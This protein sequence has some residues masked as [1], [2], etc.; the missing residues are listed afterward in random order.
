MTN[1]FLENYLRMYSD[2]STMQEIGDAHGVTRQNVSYHLRKYKESELT[3][4]KHLRL[5]DKE[6]DVGMRNLARFFHQVR[7]HLNR[8]AY[9]YGCRCEYCLISNCEYSKMVR[10]RKKA[11]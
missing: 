1:K 2:G 3:W 7:T 8:S 6:V 4:I 9:T 10:E 5:A 11:A